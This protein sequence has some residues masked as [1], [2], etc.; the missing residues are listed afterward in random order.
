M[1]MKILIADDHELYRDALSIL[2]QRLD[3]V[4]EIHPCSSYDELLVLARSAADWDLM[5][6][7]LNM[8]GLSYYDGIAQLT[9][10]HPNTPVIVVTSSEDPKDTLLALEA[11]ALGYMS[12][13]MKSKDMLKAIQLMLSSGI[14]IHP[15]HQLT[16]DLS[17]TSSTNATASL[18]KL[19]PRQQEVLKRLCEGE[20]NKRIALNLDL[21]EH[22]VKLHVRAILQALNAENRTQAV[23]VAKSLLF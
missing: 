4:T 22:T 9:A 17:S 3:P 12:K 13:A 14:S 1:S 15:T 10:A 5:L 11:G 8:P 2:V 16:H 7:D 20:S 19:T 21:S 6:V 23:I 18:D